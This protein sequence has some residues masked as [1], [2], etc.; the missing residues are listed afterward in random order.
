MY[1]FKYILI[2][3]IFVNIVGVN[4]VR[5]TYEISYSSMGIFYKMTCFPAGYLSNFM[6][7]TLYPGLLFDAKCNNRN[8]ILYLSPDS[9]FIDHSKVVYAHTL[10]TF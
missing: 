5:Q 1:I 8:S 3:Y 10:S 7:F 4:I 2:S 9:I 6:F